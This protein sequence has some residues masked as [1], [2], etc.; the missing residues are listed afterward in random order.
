V[1]PSVGQD[2]CILPDFLKC[3]MQQKRA[4]ITRSHLINYNKNSM[5]AEYVVQALKPI[6]CRILFPPAQTGQGLTDVHSGSVR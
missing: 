6:T 5:P 4:F 3:D 1:Q 2:L